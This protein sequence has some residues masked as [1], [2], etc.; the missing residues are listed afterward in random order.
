[1]TID[2]GYLGG[3]RGLGSPVLVWDSRQGAAIE[4]MQCGFHE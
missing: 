4:S 2:C 1:M 3:A